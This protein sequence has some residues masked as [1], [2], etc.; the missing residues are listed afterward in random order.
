MRETPREG[1]CEL[2]NQPWTRVETQARKLLCD[3]CLS[4]NEQDRRQR[5]ELH[6]LRL[7]KAY[8]L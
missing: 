3:K 4:E 2:H 7:H 1:R 6:R 8:Q 5:L